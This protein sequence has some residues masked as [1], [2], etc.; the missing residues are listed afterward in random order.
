MKVI[1]T[2]IAVFVFGTVFLSAYAAPI[3]NPYYDFTNECSTALCRGGYGG[4]GPTVSILHFNP[5]TNGYEFPSKYHAGERYI[6]NGAISNDNYCKK[7]T[8][9]DQEYRNYKLNPNNY[10]ISN[11]EDLKFSFIVQISKLGGAEPTVTYLD[12]F[13]GVVK[14]G[15]KKHYSFLWVPQE[16]GQYV[17]ERF[18]IYDKNNPIPLAP[19]H[20]THVEVLEEQKQPTKTVMTPIE[21]FQYGMSLQKSN[22]E[23]RFVVAIKA[24]NGMPVSVTSDTKE[25]LI[26]RGWAKPA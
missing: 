5:N 17:I 12:D 15:D 20:A 14:P 7:T 18:I 3:C 26:E 24:S 10:T 6:L 13:S 16:K 25:K 8:T 4:T 9:L 21:L 2:S 23:K 11:Y 19:R 22:D 1:I